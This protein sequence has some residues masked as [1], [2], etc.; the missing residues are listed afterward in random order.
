MKE[1]IAEKSKEQGYPVSRLP[2]FTQDEIKMLI[3]SAD[4]FGM[5]HYSSY[6]TTTGKGGGVPSFYDD[7]TTISWQDSSWPNSASSWLKVCYNSLLLICHYLQST[8]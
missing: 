1:R 2:E 3:G 7:H 4:F 5:N 8:N 6:L